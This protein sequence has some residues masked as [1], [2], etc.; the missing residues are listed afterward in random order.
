MKLADYVIFLYHGGVIEADSA[1]N[2][3]KKPKELMTQ[4]YLKGEYLDEIWL[5][6]EARLI[7]K[8]TDGAG[9]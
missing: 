1:E 5:A 9:I 8:V 6:K 7:N 2:I 3:F 4:A